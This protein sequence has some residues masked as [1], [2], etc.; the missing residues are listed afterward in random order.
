M[1]ERRKDEVSD[2][3]GGDSA[4]AANA[5]D[6]EGLRGRNVTLT[7]SAPALG[8][9]DEQARITPTLPPAVA[10]GEPIIEPLHY[11]AWNA[12]RLK[13]SSLPPSASSAPPAGAPITPLPPKR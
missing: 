9:D 8:L 6:D 1:V 12:D 7:L 11:D 5:F 10:L 2:G 13:R 3:W 4:S